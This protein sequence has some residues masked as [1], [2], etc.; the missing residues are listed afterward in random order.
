[1]NTLNMMKID[2]QLWKIMKMMRMMEMMKN[3]KT[4]KI[5]NMM[6]HDENHEN[7]EKLLSS[8]FK[9]RKSEHKSKIYEAS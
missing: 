1:M 9:K 5:I 2:A 8:S 6:N 7:N 4:L 3:I